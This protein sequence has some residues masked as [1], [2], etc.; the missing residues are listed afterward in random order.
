[1]SSTS[2]RQAFLQ[3]EG[4]EWFARNQIAAG[5]DADEFLA[6]DPSLP[7]LLQ[8]PLADGSA[9]TVAE[10]GCG[11]GL[12]LAALRQQRGWSVMGLD[13]S[14]D[15]VVEARNA[16]LE[17]VVGTADTLPYADE[18][19]D[20]LIFGFC[21]CWCD[22]ADLFQIAAEAHRVLKPASWLAILDFWSP[23]PRSN[24]YHHRQG[25]HTFKAD[26]PAMF[27]WHPAYVVTDHRLR[28]HTTRAFTDDPE[29]WV[30]YT[31]LRRCEA[32]AQP[33]HDGSDD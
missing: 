23:H 14:R 25:F 8:L 27:L 12:R 2:Q 1:M 32:W 5:E 16:G 15:A 3:G 4:D 31:V 29:E 28:H 21:L 6:A 18:S 20:L 10:V 24:P 19:L 30:G 11:Q 17:A 13:P 22:R 7:M 9:T 26:L 33:Q